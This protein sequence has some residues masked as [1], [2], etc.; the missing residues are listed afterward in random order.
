MVVGIQEQLQMMPELIV[1]VVV[2]AP[3]SRF[4]D[5]AVHPLDLTIGPGMARL[6]QAM[7]DV[8]LGTSVLKGMSAEDLASFHGFFDQR[9][10]RTGVARRGE[11]GAVVGEHGVHLVRRRRDQRAQKVSSDLS[12]G[13]LMQLS[14]SDLAGAID[15][16]EQVEPPFLR[17]HLG[18]VDVTRRAALAKVADGI[19]LELLL[20]RL[21]TRHLRQAADA[22][23]LQTAMQR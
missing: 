20:G 8:I 13:F 11:V 18:D 14:E 17:V 1:A 3:D 12:C 7:I 9:G 22:M 2:V 6:G 19:S 23:A 5:R 16:H 10:C 4:L 21:V 15:G